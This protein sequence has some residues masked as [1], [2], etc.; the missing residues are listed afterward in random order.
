MELTLFNQKKELLSFF[1]NDLIN[2][3]NQ[4]ELTEIK[5][6]LKESQMN[7]HEEHFNLVVLGEFS[8]GKS[9]FINALLGERILPSATKPTTTLINRIVSSNSSHFTLH[10]RESDNVQTLDEASFKSLVAPK[11]PDPENSIE[12][13]EYEEHLSRLSKI[14][15]I[16]IGHDS[17]LLEEGVEIIDTPGTNDLDQAREEITFTFIPK[18]DAAVLLLSATQILSESEMSFLKE[19]ILANDIQKIFFVINAKD[20]LDGEEDEKKVL[21]YAKEHLIPHVDHPKIFMVSSRGALNFKR[22][23]NGEIIKGK[24]PKTL[25]ETGF[26]ELESE[27]ARYLTEERAKTK[28]DK[29]Y[30]RIMKQADELLKTHIHYRKAALELSGK[31]LETRIKQLRPIL[32]Q[33]RSIA[34]KQ[35]DETELRLRESGRDYIHRYKTGLEE[36]S[37]RANMAINTYS[38][39]LEGDKIARHIE[40]TV[41]NLQKNLDYEMKEYKKQFIDQIIVDATKRLSRSLDDLDFEVSRSL[42]VSNNE[43][44]VHSNSSLQTIQNFNSESDGLALGGLLVGGAA[45]LL[46]SAPFIIIPVAM[47]GGK[48]LETLLL[49]KKRNRFLEQ[50]KSQVSKRY[51]EIIPQQTDTFQENYYKSIKHTISTV[52]GQV[53]IKID[54]LESQLQTLLDEKRQLEQD[55]IAERKRL[56]DMSVVI[57][58]IITTCTGELS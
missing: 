10:Y 36:I 47:F 25:E 2:I 18:S 44:T 35:L 26:P 27:I 42:T 57:Q 34:K 58:K 6:L 15:H 30:K 29:H 45:F 14:S 50:V 20:K 9:T 16:T 48:Y 53:K 28:L 13:R 22:T 46:F 19:R 41:A 21:A 7:L 43:V 5:T 12:M 37:L 56:E 11:E 52:H 55:D 4:L 40:S 31:E 54:S 24:T 23:Q 39:P 8:R 32:E 33:T 49:E 1:Y 38:G 3:T 51:Q 17:S